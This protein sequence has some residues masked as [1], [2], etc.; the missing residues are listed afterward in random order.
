MHNRSICSSKF[1]GWI[2]AAVFSAPLLVAQVTSPR[3]G[4]MVDYPVANGWEQGR[5]VAVDKNNFMVQVHEMN[6][7][8][9]WFGNS[10]VRPA[11]TGT[12]AAAITPMTG[13]GLVSK[14]E[15]LSY[16]TTHGMLNGHYT[17]DPQV[18]QA[19]AQAIKAR[20]ADF[21]WTYNGVEPVTSASCV[22][23]KW[24]VDSAVKLN[25]GPPKQLGWLM[26]KWSLGIIAPTVDSIHPDGWVWRREEYGVRSGFVRINPD[27]TF[28]WQIFPNDPPSKQIKGIWRLATD[29]EMGLQGGAG[30]VLQR[31][32]SNYDW[33]AFPWAGSVNHDMIDVQNL[34]YRG[35]QRR[36]GSRD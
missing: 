5:V 32:E 24:P 13:T 27:H 4:D 6:G 36:L 3:V 29:D 17:Q 8:D 15:I 26:G 33:I 16:I 28:V 12:R 10:A 2:F 19:V 22:I 35:A 20:G 18:C 9:G 11:T 31:G 23:G 14:Q 30:N 34:Q 21:R 25:Y 1:I 7:L